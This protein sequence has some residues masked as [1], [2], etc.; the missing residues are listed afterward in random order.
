[1]KRTTVFTCSIYPD[2]TRVWYHFVRRYTDASDVETV[3][4]DCGSRLEQGHFPD[5]RI[6]THP[7]TDH[8]TKIDH[9]VRTSAATPFV[10]LLDDDVFF[11]SDRTEPDATASLAVD[12]RAAVF[13]YKPRLW[14]EFDID[15]CRH[16]VMGSYALVFKPQVFRDEELSFCTRKTSDTKIRNGEG[17]YDTAD[18][19]NEQLIR[20]GYAIRVADDSDR[21]SKLRSYS[22]VSSGFVNF[23]R[24]RLMSRRY[25]LTRSRSEW[26]R[27]IASTPRVLEWA[28]GVAAAAGLYRALF[29]EAPQFDDFFGY[30]DLLG[31]AAAITDDEA[32]DTANR[33]IAGYRELLETLRRAA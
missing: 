1:M 4:Y 2:L 29:Y 10:F 11:L 21:R 25:R 14:W 26:E 28:C 20:R 27:R 23:A 15:G 17:Y 13:S 32:R 9:F 5:A 3:I 8:G 16:P 7:N 19:A 12:P 6:V 18:Y 30:D 22:A 24:R 31:I 33:T